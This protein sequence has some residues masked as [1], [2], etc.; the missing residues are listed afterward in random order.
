V[1]DASD[2]AQLKK[3][4]VEA[5]R[6]ARE[7]SDTVRVVM[8]TTA[9]RRWM[10]R[11][12]SLC[13]VFEANAQTDPVRVGFFEGERNIGLAIFA[14]VHRAAADLYLKMMAEQEEKE[15]VEAASD[16]L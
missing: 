14:D 6:A 1:R 3:L 5:R 16:Q 15:D 7:D 2:K 10:H 13:H 11:I 8:S 12:L 4:E 9:G